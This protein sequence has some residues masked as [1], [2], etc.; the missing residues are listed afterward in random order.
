MDRWIESLPFPLASILW[1]YQAEANAER[2]CAYLVHLFEG[3]VVFLVDLHVSALHRDPKVMAE[4]S[5]RASVEVSYSRSS[6]GI[7]VDLLARLAKRARELIATD[8][9][10]ASELYRVGDPGRLEAIA[11]KP[12]IVALMD[13]AAAYRRDWFGHPAV[14]GESEWER[15]LSQAEGTL[16]RV[17][18]GLGDAFIGWELV[19]AGQGAN[20]GGVITTSIERLTGSRS[21]FRKGRVGLREWPEEGQLYMLEEGASLP[22]RLSPL[23]TLQR[24]PESVEDACYFYDRLQDGGVRWISY[25]FEQQPEVIRPNA[26]VV[27]LIG[28]LN[29]LG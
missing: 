5:H 26:E 29:S 23:F 4:V 20:R 24:S 6:I 17:R 19:R 21:L 14:V 15:R 22:L 2:R 18:S 10:L 7:W 28:E 16:A 1:R 8:S 11:R 12:L 9:A 13:E 27:Q 3:T 25:H